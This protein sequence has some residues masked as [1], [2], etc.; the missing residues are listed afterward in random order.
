[1][2]EHFA[3]GFAFA[4]GDGPLR[5]VAERRVQAVCRRAYGECANGQRA[6]GEQ[7]Y[8]DCAESQQADRDS[9]ACDGPER[10]T[11][12]GEQ[13]EGDEAYGDDSGGNKSNSHSAACHKPDGE[14]PVC[15]ASGA[16]VDVP[17]RHAM[18]KPRTFALKAHRAE[19]EVC[20]LRCGCLRVGGRVVLE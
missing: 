1:M 19:M 5:A 6:A 12:E 3:D 13:A 4:E 7:P 20:A 8:G 15:D 17:Q 16:D 18:Y 10:N 14:D 2:P 9:A 11:S